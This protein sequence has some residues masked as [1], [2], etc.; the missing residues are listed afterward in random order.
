LGASD[1]RGLLAQAKMF[2]ATVALRRNT[3]Q[4]PRGA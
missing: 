4:L 2:P 3:A 1:R